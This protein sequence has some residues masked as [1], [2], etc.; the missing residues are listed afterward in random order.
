LVGNNEVFVKKETEQML[1]MMM[2]LCVCMAVLLLRQFK[3]YSYPPG[4]VPDADS[5]PVESGVA[6]VQVV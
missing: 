2:I 3:E 6:A 5:L 4:I 1:I